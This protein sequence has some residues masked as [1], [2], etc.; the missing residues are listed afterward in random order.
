MTANAASLIATEVVAWH[1]RHPL[2]RRITPAQVQGIGVVALPFL[3]LGGEAAQVE[4]TA[5]AAPDATQEGSLRQRALAQAS[6]GASE[7]AG[8]PAAAAATSSRVGGA[9]VFRRAFDEDFAAPISPRRAAAFAARHGADHDPAHGAWPCREVLASAQRSGA[10]ATH[11]RYVRTA[12]IELNDRRARVLIQA[13]AA[14]PVAI[15]GPRLYS[16]PRIGAL[17]MLLCILPLLVVS[18]WPDGQANATA[19]PA[20]P[21]AP[22]VAVTL[23]APEAAPEAQPAPQAPPSTAPSA[24]SGDPGISADIRPRLDPEV[25]R[26]ARRES[27]AARASASL[28]PPAPSLPPAHASGLVAEA[29]PEDA[30]K[31]F[32][33]VA[34][35]TRSR[36]AS[37]ILLGPM[38]ALA[39]REA[40]TGRR[41]EVL[42][43]HEG[44]R[45]SWWPFTS[46]RDAERARELLAGAGFTVDVV[47]F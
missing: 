34:R 21:V 20:Q 4:A 16:R 45:A 10:A 3:I 18:A 13:Q 41:T 7:P 19:L 44:Y 15:I 32:A 6:G 5:V 11:R 30:G 9:R 43:S 2:A 8:L 17:A 38:Q 14:E 35:Q 42:P 22:P 33:L 1:N 29:A 46:R 12:A 26:Q 25:A 36:A 27:A 28:P 37:Q 39:A 24:P 47:E 40:P 23:A 31:T